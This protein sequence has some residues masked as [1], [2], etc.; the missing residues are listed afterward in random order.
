MS[1]LELFLLPACFFAAMYD[2]LFYKI[3]NWLVLLVIGGFFAKSLFAISMGAPL[4]ILLHP[5]ITFLITLFIGFI[6]FAYGAMGAGDAKLL[7]ACSLW[8][9]DI[10]PINFI[11]LVTISGGILALIYLI[12]KKPLDFIRDLLLSKIVNKFDGDSLI[13]NEKNMVPYAI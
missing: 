7:A 3:P 11:M 9:A 6:L 1:M 8:M 5:S 10:N 13:I 12:M 2:F 4:D